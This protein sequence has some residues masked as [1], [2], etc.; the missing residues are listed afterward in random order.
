MKK[1]QFENPWVPPNAN[2]VVDRDKEKKFRS[3]HGI[4]IFLST[5]IAALFYKVYFL[6]EKKI[7]TYFWGDNINPFLQMI[8]STLFFFLI[9]K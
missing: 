8:I 3:R 1:K 4:A 7:F 6:Q 2:D 5:P 9:Q